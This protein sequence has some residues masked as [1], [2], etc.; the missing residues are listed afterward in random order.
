MKGPEVVAIL[1]ASLAALASLFNAAVAIFNAWRDNRGL[2]I[3][4]KPR[5]WKQDI[6]WTLRIRNYARSPN[7]VADVK[8]L[9]DCEGRQFHYFPAP[10]LYEEIRAFSTLDVNLS[11]PERDAKGG[12]FETIEFEIAPMRGRRHTFKFKRTDLPAREA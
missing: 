2:K 11:L 3:A 1:V 7:S 8:C 9:V 4:L 10:S 5:R 12:D 6:V